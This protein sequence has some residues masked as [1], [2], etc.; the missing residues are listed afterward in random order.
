M[1]RKWSTNKTIKSFGRRFKLLESQ[2]L[3][4]KLDQNQALGLWNKCVSDCRGYLMDVPDEFLPYYLVGWDPYDDKD[5]I[6][7]VMSV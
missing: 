1:L 2:T 3:A 5:M 7:R 6:R 4:G